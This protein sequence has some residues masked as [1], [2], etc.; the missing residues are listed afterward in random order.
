MDS[1]IISGERLQKLAD[2]SICLDTSHLHQ[3]TL[4]TMP[5]CSINRFNINMIT[6]EIKVL[7]V[8]PDVLDEFFQKIYPYIY[9]KFILMTH[10]SDIGIDENRFKHILD[11]S[12]CKIIKWFA[13]NPL[14]LHSKIIA[15]PIGIANT[16]WPHGNINTL[17]EC[18]NISYKKENLCYFQFNLHTN[19]HLRSSIK[20][21]II[22]NTGLKMIEQSDHCT[23]LHTLGT[24][25]YCICPPGNGIDS[26]RFWEC[27]YLGVIPV[28]EYDIFYDQFKELPILIVKNWSDLSI[29]LMENEYEK[30][31]KE[32]IIHKLSYYASLLHFFKFFE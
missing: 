2:F 17:I 19:Y 31:N 28:V 4:L 9:H 24:Y 10:N 12:E 3:K 16:H 5:H 8:Y 25:K 27:L 29:E 23:Y 7:F 13:Q 18:I 14:F 30:I 11:S 22:Q 15:L 1:E 32:I 6:P 21:I 26:H 20:D